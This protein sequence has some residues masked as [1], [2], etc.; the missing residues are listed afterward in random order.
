MKLANIDE[1]TEGRRYILW[2]YGLQMN[3]A[4]IHK[5]LPLCYESNFLWG[6]YLHLDTWTEISDQDPTIDQTNF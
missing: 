3:N 6:G 4:I 2:I 1:D 5:G